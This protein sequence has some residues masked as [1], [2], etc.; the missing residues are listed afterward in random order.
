MI[1]LSDSLVILVTLLETYLRVN[2]G[3]EEQLQKEKDE[4]YVRLKT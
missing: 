2:D 3:K 4:F 1:K